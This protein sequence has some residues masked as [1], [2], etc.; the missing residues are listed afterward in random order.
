[1]SAT[2]KATSVGLII[3]DEYSLNDH[4]EIFNLLD[5]EPDFAPRLKQAI[6]QKF[7]EVC[8]DLATNFNQGFGSPR[9]D[10]VMAYVHQMQLCTTV[11]HTL[12]PQ[13]RR[14]I[15]EARDA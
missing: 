14:S 1:M 4:L 6:T 9:P 8:I 12:Y 13:Y 7:E 3:N 15:D 10:L 5:L 11:L 2:I